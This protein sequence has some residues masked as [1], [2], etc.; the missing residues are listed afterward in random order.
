MKS[1]NTSK[2]K[3]QFRTGLRLMTAC[4][5][6]TTLTAFA[7][8]PQPTAPPPQKL[9]SVLGNCRIFP[10][11]NYWNTPVDTLPVHSS[12][13][14]WI[15][16]IGA[17]RG[18]HMDF[19]SGTWDGGPIG[20]PFN[21]VSGAQTNKYNVDFYYSG[22]SDPGPY[23]IPANPNQEWG[24]DH[25]ILTID[26]DNCKLYEMYDAWQ[27]NGAWFGGSG[28][29]WDLNTNDLRTDTWTSADAAGLPILP[30]LA[31]YDEVAAGKIAHALRFTT[32]CTADYYIWPARHVAQSGSCANPVPFGARF[33]L[34]AS[35]NIAG[36][37]ADAQVILQ[38]MKT[39]GIIL[40]DNGSPWYVSGAPDPGW[41][42]DIL[43]EMDVLNGSNFEAVDTSGWMV[44][45]NSGATDNSPLD[46]QINMHPSNPTISNTATFT[47]LR[48]DGTST[49][50]CKLDAGAFTPC[51]SPKTYSGLSVGPHTFSVHAT[52]GG[53]NIDIEP[54][55]FTWQRQVFLDVP[56]NYWAASFIER[57]SQAAITSG[58]GS[59]NY[60]PE[61]AVTRAQMAIFLERGI[62]GSSFDPGT[63][64][65]T[66]TDTTG[67]WARYWIEALRTDG[68]TSGCGG[69]VY[70][71][72]SPVN[73]DQMAV[74]LLRAKHGKMYIPPHVTS[75]G[76]A[77][78]PQGYWD[79]DWI[80][81]LASEGI[82]SGCSASNYCP[83]AAVTR[84]QM[85]V[86]L[87]RAF[88]LP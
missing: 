59:G 68:I 63:P 17:T 76:F 40:A 29:I 75:T 53:I 44:D 26:T 47:F 23:P 21:L 1:M 83:S 11:N 42:N 88:S 45:Y 4:L 37:S 25:H 54:P 70:C 7:G 81:Q 61:D 74:F 77:D 86:F 27:S 35:Y 71:P 20:I 15:N 66:F 72:E 22:D 18:F 52:N 34:K 84:A 87:V 49:F 33:R 39:Y 36:F 31:R 38:A 60:C 62:H 56:G 79:A 24:S 58:C 8:K 82:T 48:P 30:G 46:T 5:L 3:T 50:E 80:A 78:V 67:N 16:T 19:G 41:N 14:A 10:H 69:N 64:L 6:V 9:T 51:T 13:A 28:A 43:H 55:I 65:I 57:L 85:A 73:R 32:N 12:S 2:L